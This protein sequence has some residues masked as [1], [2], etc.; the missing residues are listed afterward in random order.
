MMSRR[1]QGRRA[2][3]GA[4]YAFS[5]LWAAL[6]ALGGASPGWG[7]ALTETAPAGLCPGVEAAL[8]LEDQPLAVR[9]C[10]LEERGMRA[11]LEGRFSEA[12]AIWAEL[13]QVAPA[14]GAAGLGEVDT[15]W[16]RL[17]L[18]EGA[19]D[20][21]T[22]L[23]NA[24]AEVIALADARLAR[25]PDD[26]DAL[27]QK[28]AAL[29]NRARLYGIR[30]RYL[31]AG[32]DGEKGRKL[33]ERSLELDPERM[34]S[35]YALG[36]Y[37][38]YT[39]IAPK[40]VQWM[41]WLWFVPEGDRAGGLRNLEIVRDSDGLHATGAAFIL[42]NV[43]TYHAP[44]DLP[45]ALA[46]GR[47][48][49]AR[50][51][52][53]ALFHSELVEV[54]LKLGLYEEAVL[55]AQQLEESQPQ[56]LEAQVRPQLARILRAQAVLLSGRPQEAWGILEPMDASTTPL[57]IWGGAWLHL[58]RGQ[59]HDAQGRREAAVA[60]YEQV[61]ALKGARYNPRAGMIAKAALAEPFAPESYQELPMVGAGS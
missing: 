39:D 9:A 50:Y 28:G 1:Q 57:P 25:N 48:L 18:D 2:P 56:E 29:F 49:H 41:S 27:A 61:L 16:W 17:M 42:M 6:L 35:R 34:D 55:T 33:L 5:A 58:V 12:E 53:N 15:V 31:K 51:P 32:G 10:L 59:V 11:N 26:A 47:E 44:M 21:D 23:L 24:C 43:H 13:R 3:F 22:T 38:Y 46:T 45:A 8:A 37:T 52:G 14:D 7:E 40:V 19:T 20:N 30:G 60:E 54:L 36:L 4:L